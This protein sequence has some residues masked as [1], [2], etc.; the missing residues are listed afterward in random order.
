MKGYKVINYDKWTSLPEIFTTLREA[1]EAKK[2]STLGK[3]TVVEYFNSRNTRA[4][5][6]Y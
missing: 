4:K 1:K 6:I 2:T 3:N 5:R